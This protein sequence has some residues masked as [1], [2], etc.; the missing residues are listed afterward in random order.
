MERLLGHVVSALALRRECLPVLVACLLCV[1]AV[2]RNTSAGSTVAYREARAVAC[3]R[4][5]A[6]DPRQLDSGME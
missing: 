2:G 6:D 5:H 4:P 3:P 1:R